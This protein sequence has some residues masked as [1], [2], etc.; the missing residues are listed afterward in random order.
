MSVPHRTYWKI[1]MAAVH[2]SPPQM[3]RQAVKPGAKEIARM[4]WSI[5]ALNHVQTTKSECSKTTTDCRVENKT[6][7]LLKAHAAETQIKKMDYI[8][9]SRFEKKRRSAQ[10]SRTPQHCWQ[11]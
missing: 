9:K 4:D 2:H 3:R 7:F 8:C 1:D 10:S 5:Q 11:V 6:L